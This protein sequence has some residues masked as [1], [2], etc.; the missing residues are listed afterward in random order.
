MN[1]GSLQ[2]DNVGSLPNDNA[3]TLP[4][5]NA[6]TLPNVNLTP[7][8]ADDNLTP[9]NTTVNL[10]PNDIISILKEKNKNEE[11]N[12]ITDNDTDNNNDTNTNTN[13]IQNPVNILQQERSKITT[14][15]FIPNEQKIMELGIIDHESNE[16][17]KKA[18]EKNNIYNF[19]IKQINENISNSTIGFLDD[20]F[21]KPE[22]NNWI[23][24][25]Q[26]ILLKE[27]RYVY[28]GFL[29]I[30]FVIFMMLIE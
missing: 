18:Y 12:I 16:I 8:N 11:G 17:I 5:D 7:S 26:I 6:G 2:N 27:E 28:L 30:M 20:L 14:N 1:Q 19:S 21:I 23:E 15:P 3:G 4:N 13:T 24:Y 25:L 22:N 9:I 29:L 10:I